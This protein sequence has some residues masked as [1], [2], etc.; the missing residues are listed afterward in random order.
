MKH[1]QCKSNAQ[2]L[3]L[4]E[5][6]YLINVLIFCVWMSYKRA[7]ASLICFLFD[8]TSTMNTCS[9][10]KQAERRQPFLYLL[11]ILPAASSAQLKA[12]QQ[13]NQRRCQNIIVLSS[14]CIALHINQYTE[15]LL[16]DLEK[17]EYSSA[18][19]PRVEMHEQ[20]PMYQIHAMHKP[21]WGTGIMLIA[22]PNGE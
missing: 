15:A 12:G 18:A 6:A 14:F 1:Q 10:H 19:A 9:K 3:L 7:T 8:L 17:D 4:S 5:A 16:G 20:L 2:Q 11:Y 21:L 22:M 13:S